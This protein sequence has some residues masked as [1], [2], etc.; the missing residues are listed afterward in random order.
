M[1][2]SYV[3]EDQE[4]WDMN[5]SKI[6]FAYNTS[7][8]S[9]TKQTPFELQF[10]RKPTIP[11]DIVIPNIELHQREAVVKEYKINDEQLGDTTVLE[12]I[13]DKVFED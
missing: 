11:I 10:G 6:S 8:H 2:R 3:D 5:L 4:N 1:I 13:D 7:T 9:T 12:D